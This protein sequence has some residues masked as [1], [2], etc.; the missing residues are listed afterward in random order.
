MVLCTKS[1][2]L[3]LK[4]D[5]AYQRLSQSQGA[6]NKR[7]LTEKQRRQQEELAEKRKQEKRREYKRQKEAESRRKTQE[8]AEEARRKDRER[9]ATDDEKRK[10]KERMAK[11]RKAMDLNASEDEKR[12]GRER[13]AK[14]RKAKEQ[15]T[16]VTAGKELAYKYTRNKGPSKKW[17]KMR[18]QEIGFC[19]FLEEL[20]FLMIIGDRTTLSRNMVHCI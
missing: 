9:K 6:K 11:S 12:K 7:K 14:S 4:L 3:K 19:Y 8:A 10:A 5:K 13:K 18:D 17:L 1:R 16:K 15:P 2:A 20:D